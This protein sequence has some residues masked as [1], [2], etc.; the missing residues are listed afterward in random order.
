M[1]PQHWP[2]QVELSQHDCTSGQGDRMREVYR[3]SGLSLTGYCARDQQRVTGRATAAK[4]SALR[5]I[6]YG[7]S[8]ALRSLARPASKAD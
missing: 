2:A 6:R 8:W 7:S 5:R 4:S 1:A 3:D